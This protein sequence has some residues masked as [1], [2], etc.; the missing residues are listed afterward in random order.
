MAHSYNVGDRVRININHFSPAV[1]KSLGL[2]ENEEQ[3]ADVTAHRHVELVVETQELY[4]LDLVGH[5]VNLSDVR[6]EK[7]L[8][9]AS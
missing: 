2:G 5:P 9:L 3:E 1:R 8:G 6:E 7:I 4:D